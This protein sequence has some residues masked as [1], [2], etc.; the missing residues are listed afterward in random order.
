M[1]SYP[2]VAAS[3]ETLADAL[4]PDVDAEIVGHR[5]HLAVSGARAA[6]KAAVPDIDPIR[7]SGGAYAWNPAV[8][9]ESD[10]E[11]LLR[12]NRDATRASMEA[13]LDAY[14]GEYLAGE[15]AEWIYPLR[16]RCANAY[17]T[18]LE[19]LAREALAEHDYARALDWSLRLVESDRAHEGATR[20][21]ME[22]F[23]GSGRRGAAIAEYEALA[24]YLRRHLALQPSAETAALRD[25]IARG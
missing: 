3:R 6:L 19:R 7:C 1:F 11:L 21:V 17:V 16:V 2:R 8:A 9:I 20:L 4:W 24:A 10:V 18:L 14:G 23:A 25:R 5:L 15:T 12:A 22:A 13:A